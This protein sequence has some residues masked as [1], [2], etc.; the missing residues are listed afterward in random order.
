MKICCLCETWENGGVESFIV[1][2]YEAMNLNT[3]EID[4]ACMSKKTSVFNEKLELLPINFIAIS[5]DSD[6]FIKKHCNLI[7]FLKNNKYEVVHCHAFHGLSLIYLFYA[8]L[9]GVKV[10]IAHSHNNDLR[11]SPTRFIKIL[12]HRLSC[13][14][15]STVPTV[16]LA[17]SEPAAKF[18]SFN[19]KWEYLKNGICIEKFS[20]DKNARLLLRKELDLEDFLVIGH[21]GRFSYQKNQSFLLELAKRCSDSAPVKLLLIGEGQDEELL[22]AKAT[23]LG[24]EKLVV[25]Q[26]PTTEIPALLSAMDVFVFPSCFEA[27]GIVVLEAQANGL[28]IIC[29]DKIPTESRVVSDIKVLSLDEEIQD[30]CNAIIEKGIRETVSENQTELQQQGFHIKE[31]ANRLKEIYSGENR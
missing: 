19:K 23:E 30:W 31:V 16:R 13:F 8:M 20:F 9:L 17:C 25:F 28:P 27:F 22:K 14:L 7:K 21:I 3:I 11:K 1:N 5:S 12:I 2:T 26:K 29:S 24:I 18:M 10:R 15:F 6:S 4:L